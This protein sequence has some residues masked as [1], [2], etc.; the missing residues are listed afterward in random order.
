[1]AD[2][3]FFALRSRAYDLAD[4]G[5]YKSWAEVAQALNAEGSA[6]AL[7]TRLASDAQAV[8]MITRCCTQARA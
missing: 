5:R 8:M 2:D 6:P 4:S 7:V 3:A 1:M